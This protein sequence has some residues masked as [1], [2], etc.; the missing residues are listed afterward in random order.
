MDQADD[1]VMADGDGSSSENE[2]SDSGFELDISP[3][4]TKLLMQLEKQLKDNPNVYDSHF[5]EVLRRCKMSSRL[6]EARQAMHAAFPLTEALWLAWLSDET[7]GVA[8]AEDIARLEALM[9]EA[10]VDYLSIPLWAQYLEFVRDFD[11][12]VAAGSAEG[13]EKMRALCEQALTAGGLHVSE[14]SRLW[15][16]Y[17]GYERGLLEADPKEAQAERVRSLWT[18]QLQVPLADGAD[19][20]AAYTAWERDT[21]GEQGWQVPAVLQAG[22]AKAQHAAELRQPY[23][24]SVAS[25]KPATAD[26][27]AAYMAYIKVEE[28]AG[29][30]SRAVYERA[31]AAFPVTHYLWLQYT[32]Y[33]EAHIKVNSVVNAAYA[34]AL[35]NCPWVGQLWSRALRALERTGAADEQHEAL[36]AR[37]LSAG[38]QS[39]EDY[40]EVMLARLDALRRRG[41]D[42]F[43]SLRAAF[44]AA[45]DLLHSYF[46]SHLDRAF[47]LTSYWADCEAGLGGD[48]KAARAVWEAA[49]KGPA[50]R[51][52]DT[53][54]AYVD[55]ERRRG[56]TREAR[57]LYKRCYSR[58]M[59]E[60][61]QA[62]LCDA[63]LRFERE[64]GSA[65]D[66]LAACIK[67]E[68]ILQESQAA[69][70]A[71]ADPA[72]HAAAQSAAERA[73]QL[74]KEEMRAMRQQADPNFSA[75]RKQ[76][77]EESREGGVAAATPASAT[78]GKGEMLPPPPKKPKTAAAAAAAAAGSSVDH[79]AAAGG[80]GSGK[81]QTAAAVVAAQVQD[82]QPEAQQVS[83]SPAPQQ[84]PPTTQSAGQ[85]QEAE[86]QPQQQNAG[87]EPPPQQHGR[88]QQHW[89]QEQQQQQ[90][91]VHK[92]SGLGWRQQRRSDANTAFVKYLAEGV[93]EEAVRELFGGCGPLLGVVMGRD[94]ETDRLKGFAYVH[95]ATHE[96]LEAAIRLNGSEFHGKHILVAPSQ[97]PS[98][99]GQQAHK[100]QATPMQQPPQQQQQQGGRGRGRGGGSDG[101]ADGRGGGRGGRGGGR[102]GGMDGG[103]R[104]RGGRGGGREGGRGRGDLPGPKHRSVIDLGS[105][106]PSAATE[107]PVATSTGFLPRA[108]ALR[109]KAPGGGADETPKSNAEFRKLFLAKK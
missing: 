89:Q 51:H 99:H 54:A 16:L 22:Y 52:A 20:L 34:R 59:E 2:S 3:E 10:T 87:G 107:R 82:G 23:E 109:G 73:P 91:Q 71:A 104:G 26:L 5:I 88:Q 97:P 84:Q 8:S 24:A 39:Y 63:W 19:T 81:Q 46:P 41:A 98:A 58:K 68:P 65:E 37:A 14:G 27:L 49:V 60:G 90:Q 17:L 1:E 92:P 103:G 31:V 48:V 93:E 55:F 56:H 72:Q 57:T 43:P 35:R 96:G 85:A 38:L 47:R 61:G 101:G 33:L 42:A 50:G 74:S 70:V 45:D 25:G 86:G 80:S 6:H 21:R 108:A 53:W 4:D 11:P 64:E 18:R 12:E 15:A 7:D 62:L 36:Y 32:R 100:Q 79:Q 77:G 28:R 105:N 76:R 30:P 67:A 13:R 40:L 9:S 102:A 44:R 83:R 106:E 29:D 66:H 69:A 75:K 94:K 78:E 95:F